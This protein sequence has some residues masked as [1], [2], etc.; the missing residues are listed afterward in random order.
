MYSKG[1]MTGTTSTTFEPATGIKRQDL[2]VTLYRYANY[3][4]DNN[5]AIKRNA[6]SKSADITGYSDYSKVYAYARDAMSW[7][8]GVKLITGEV[9][10]VLEPRKVVVRETGAEF[11]K[12]YGIFV[13]GIN[14]DR[15]AY[16]F[17]N[18]SSNFTK[19]YYVNQTHKEILYYYIDLYGESESRNGYSILDENGKLVDVTY[20]EYVEDFIKHD[21]GGSCFG[22]AA[23]VALN[24]LGK[25][26][27]V[28]DF[29]TTQNTLRDFTG[30]NS[31]LFSAINYYQVNQLSPSFRNA[32]KF[33]KKNKYDIAQ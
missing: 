2:A 4:D 32:K 6:L 7:A 18:S 25:V 15:D 1:I 17:V 28:G 21:W 3:V 13:E 23:T 8:V 10:G 20:K 33:M 19:G 30:Y 27:F 14:F 12:R 26:D 29:G 16:N 31:K 9:G 5:G 24:K 11:L 22:I